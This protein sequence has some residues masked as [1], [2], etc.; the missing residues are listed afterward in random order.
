[1]TLNALDFKLLYGFAYDLC[2]SGNLFQGVKLVDTLE[3]VSDNVFGS[4]GEMKGLAYYHQFLLRYQAGMDADAILYGE[5]V[6]Q[7][8]SDGT[9][10]RHL[11]LNLG[12]LNLSFGQFEKS[13]ETIGLSKST[14]GEIDIN[15]DE[16][17]AILQ[18]LIEEQLKNADNLS[19]SAIA[20]YH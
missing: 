20:S 5:K 1:M 18:D 2:E 3:R 4:V 10:L 16:A 6:L 11:A 17:L 14:S 19:L 12:K 8:L 7:L 13:K 15:A 9:E